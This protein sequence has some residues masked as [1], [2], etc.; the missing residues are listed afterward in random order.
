MIR[1]YTEQL[2]KA[3]YLAQKKKMLIIGELSMK[4][5]YNSRSGPYY[6]IAVAWLL[7]TVIP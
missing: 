7:A 3:I 4:K 6:F 1:I 2:S 5:V